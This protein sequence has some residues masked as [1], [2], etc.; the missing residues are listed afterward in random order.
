MAIIVI[1]DAEAEC[2]IHGPFN[3]E[4]G[5]CPECSMERQLSVADKK[6]LGVEA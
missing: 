4:T 3:S 2:T 6:F 1:N 5:D